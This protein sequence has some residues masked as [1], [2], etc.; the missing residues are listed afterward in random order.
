M[1]MTGETAFA[2][3]AP[4]ASFWSQWAKPVPF[5][6][7]DDPIDLPAPAAIPG[8]AALPALPQ[9]AAI[10]DLPGEQ[11][12]YTGVALAGRGFWPVPLF[13]G[14]SG[15]S[16]AID[17]VPL[18]RALMSG[19]KVLLQQPFSVDAAPAFLLDSRRTVGNVAIGPGVYD[20]RWVTLPQ[21]FPSG[22]LLVSRGIRAV[23]VI[24]PDSTLVP[25]DLAHVLCRWQEAGIAVHVLD[26]ANGHLATNVSI[27]KPSGFRRAWYAAVALLGLRRSNVGGFGSQIPEETGSSGFAG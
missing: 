3:W 7:A 8:T 25:S 18:I 4:A 21:D 20:N 24:E 6:Q 26:L 10:V 1:W 14:T 19:A 16:P 22:S 9:G 11:A 2:A 13:N 23:T 17:V 27:S 15:P 5:V 12:V